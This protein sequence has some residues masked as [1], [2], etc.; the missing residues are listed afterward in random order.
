MPNDKEIPTTKEHV[1]ITIAGVEEFSRHI[2]MFA[3][4]CVL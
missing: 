1:A 2:K 4:L 3:C